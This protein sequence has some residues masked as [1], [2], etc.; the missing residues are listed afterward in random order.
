MKIGEKLRVQV[1]FY[2]PDGKKQR[3]TGGLKTVSAR[4]TYINQAHRYFLAEYRV[5][6]GALRECFKF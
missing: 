6:G 3:D 4:V 5:P 2:D 1:S